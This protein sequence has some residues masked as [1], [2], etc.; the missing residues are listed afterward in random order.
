MKRILVTGASG[1]LGAN[2]AL[3]VARKYPVFGVVNLR[4]LVGT[5]FQV[6]QADLSTPGEIE[7]VLDMSQPDIIFNCAAMANVDSCEANQELA[8]KLNSVLPGK[9]AAA[10]HRTGTQLVHI[11]TD[12]VFDGKRGDYSESDL[13]IPINTYG[14][15]KLEGERVVSNNDPDSLIVRVNFYGWSLSGSRSLAEWFYNNLS[16]GE[17]VK[18]FAD[19]FFCPLLVNDLSDILLDMVEK[20]IKGLFHVVSPDII[21][22]YEFGALLART[23]GFDDQLITPSTWNDAGLRAK[24]SPNLNLRSEKLV[25]ALGKTL[26]DQP[27]GMEHFS[28]LWSAGYPQTLRSFWKS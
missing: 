19:V 5:P 11:S 12:A 10:A 25:E 20:D 2:L 9:L 17:P 7:R 23:F 22:K 3:R 8:H 1:L 16:K 18:G 28:E 15:T 21:S 24:R 4:K 14:R 27:T 6:L 26:P 13:P